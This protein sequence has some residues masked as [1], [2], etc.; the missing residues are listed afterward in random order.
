MTVIF[1]LMLSLPAL[2][3]QLYRYVWHR[4]NT[5]HR[6]LTL[7]K[8][9]CWIGGIRQLYVVIVGEVV[10]SSHLLQGLLVVLAYTYYPGVRGHLLFLNRV[11]V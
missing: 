5:L 11:R 7:M 8:T 4:K 3:T 2:L 6:S 1:R 10:S 9:E